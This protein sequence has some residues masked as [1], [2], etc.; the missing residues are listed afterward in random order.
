MGL[1]VADLLSINR[2]PRRLHPLTQWCI[3]CFSKEL[4]KC[5][6]S[7]SSR[8]N[9]VFI[10]IRILINIII[11]NMFI[12]LPRALVIVGSIW[13]FLFHNIH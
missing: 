3:L 5:H 1:V 4:F 10:L 9:P 6:F 11:L 12:I 7:Y 2:L 8:R 13:A